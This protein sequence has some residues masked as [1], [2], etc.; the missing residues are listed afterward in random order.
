VENKIWKTLI[1][2][3][4]G[5][6]LIENGIIDMLRDVSNH[7]NLHE[8]AKSWFNTGPETSPVDVDFFPFLQRRTTGDTLT[9]EESQSALDCIQT[10]AA[11]QGSGIQPRWLLLQP[12]TSVNVPISPNPTAPLLT[13]GDMEISNTESGCQL[14]QLEDD[15][16]PA[17]SP[18][19]ASP[20]MDVTGRTPDPAERIESLSTD[21]DAAAV[22]THPVVERD[23]LSTASPSPPPAYI[24]KRAP[25]ASD[26]AHPLEDYPSSL[27][28]NLMAY[29][30]PS[31]PPVIIQRRSPDSVNDLDGFSVDG[32]YEDQGNDAAK[33]LA[34]TL[35]KT[36]GMNASQDVPEASR[37][38]PPRIK[39]ARKILK[40]RKDEV[41][42]S[43]FKEV[44]FN[45]FFRLP[46]LHSLLGTLASTMQFR[47]FGK[48]SNCFDSM[49]GM[50]CLLFFFFFFFFP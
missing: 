23:V 50:M 19:W 44:S 5:N 42:N 6:I 1:K 45:S 13:L 33:S 43:T 22:P 37:N 32:A 18:S 34:Y 12:Q 24:E 3:S 4:E 40:I 26:I 31:P 21:N 36:M 2:I 29:A 35:N 27:D 46:F 41:I 38:P 47:D 8:N 10:S 49:I 30:S 15:P 48:Q 28:D 20:L 9:M 39:P 11:W 16:T 17:S 25:D 14:M 7:D